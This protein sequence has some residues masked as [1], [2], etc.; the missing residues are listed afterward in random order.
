MFGT[1]AVAKLVG[2]RSDIPRLSPHEIIP[3]KE[4]CCKL[5]CWL[6]YG[7]LAK[8]SRVHFEDQVI[9]AQRLLNYGV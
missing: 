4:T 3:D 8:S 1:Q 7:Y 5:P 9:P 2:K 6:L